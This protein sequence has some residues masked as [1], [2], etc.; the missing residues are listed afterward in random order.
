MASGGR[1]KRRGKSRPNKSGVGKRMSRVQRW[2]RNNHERSGRE[3][4]IVADIIK[5]KREGT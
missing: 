3:K 4:H 5:Q 2:A 1:R